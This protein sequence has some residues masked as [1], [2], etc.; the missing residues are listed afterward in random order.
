MIYIAR[1]RSSFSFLTIAFVS[2]PMPVPSRAGLTKSG[3]LSSGRRGSSPALN[4]W[5]GATGSRRSRQ[6]RFV[7]VLS[8]EIPLVSTREPVYGI[9]IISS[10]AGT[11]ASR[12]SPPSP[13]AML[14]Q[15]SGFSSLSAYG[16]SM[17]AWMKTV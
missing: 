3:K 9:C 13:S 5:N 1:S 7:S 17:S 15:I 4:S 10:N 12:A 6:I 2:T 8:S 11:C 14:K 16:R